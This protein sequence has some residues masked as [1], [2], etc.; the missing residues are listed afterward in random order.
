ML[1]G[2]RRLEQTQLSDRALQLYSAVSAFSSSSA[3]CFVL[4]PALQMSGFTC[5]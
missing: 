1:K 2:E 5:V 4:S 3:R